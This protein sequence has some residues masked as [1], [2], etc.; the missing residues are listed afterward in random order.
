MYLLFETICIQN[1]AIQNRSYHENRFLKSYK[2][3]YNK[4]PSFG[5]FD[6]VEFS[7]LKPAI[8]Y[9]L[10]IS[11]NEKES[12]WVISEYLNKLPHRL[13]VV[14]DNQISY[15]IKFSDRKKLNELHAKRDNADDVLIL[16]K[17]LVTDT[18]YANILFKKGSLI[19]T[20]KKPLLKGT[21][22]AR[23]IKEFSIKQKDIQLHQVHYFTHFQLINAMNDY[24]ENRWVST[25]HITLPN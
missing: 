17:G 16:K 10:K 8:K 13:Q 14:I 21:C 20:P 23:I 7:A 18:S 1:G 25:V 6:F 3:Y 2:A 24:D 9:T 22:R 5:I 12:D 11:Y 19:V 15:H 4:T